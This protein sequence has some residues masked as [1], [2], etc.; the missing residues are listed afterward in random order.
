MDDDESRIAEKYEALRDVMDEQMRRLW[1]ATEARA[2]GYGGVSI[3]AR[4]VGLTRPTITAGMKELGDARQLV[5]MAPK[6]RVRRTGAGRPR[7]T[8][9]DAGLRPALE[10][11]VEPATRGHP[12]SPLRWTCKSVRTLAAEL[13]RQGHR[14]SHQTV[15]EVLQLLGYSLQANR[16]T[17][18][19]A[20][21]ADRN[22]QFEHIARRAKEFQRRG[23]PV[24]SVD[25]KKKELVGDFKNAGREWHPQ[26]KPPAVRVHD[27]KDDEL[28]KAIPY[29]VYD[30]GANAGWV[31]VGIDH[32]TPEFAVES[33]YCWWRQMGRKTYPE[34]R[35]L[36]ITADG[37]GSNGSR[38]RLWKVALQRMADATGLEIS[39]CH[40]PPGTSK[41][42]KIEHRM[43]CHITRN[44]RGRPLESLEVVVN[45]IASTT[46]AKGLRV[47]AALDTDEYPTGVKVEDA[48]M[49][50]LRLIPDK[51][52][53]D[54]NYKIVPTESGRIRKQPRKLRSKL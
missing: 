5:P 52:H 32:D 15:S 36:L 54:W 9:S 3:V 30:L 51:F 21:H 28:G 19:G 49:A 27:F 43:F 13:S 16:K 24:I 39:V 8:E 33:I 14:V 41:W 42:N 31:S 18:E 25:T 40:F 35:E 29:G 44:W 38:A 48:M 26:G 1:A 12:M 10:E 34:A 17:R 20:G 2:L 50:A 11:L 23:Q 47:R 45:L 22:A 53:G 7:A 4:A 46:T 6:H 37:G